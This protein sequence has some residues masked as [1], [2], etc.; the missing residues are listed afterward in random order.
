MRRRS[1]LGVLFLV[2]LL[3]L[4]SAS[5]TLAQS[6]V[7]PPVASPTSSTH[8]IQ[9]ADMDLSVDPAQD[10]Y[11]YAN[12]NWLA[13]AEIPADLEWLRPIEELFLRIEDQQ[14]AQLDRLIASNTL[15]EGSDQWK[16]VEFFKQG[17]DIDT[18]NAHGISPLQPQLD[19]I[20]S[21]T[22]L[23]QLHELMASP[24]FAGTPDFFN[25]EI[26][27]DPGDST[28]N[29]AWLA[30]P[31]LGLPEVTYYTEDSEDNIAARNAYKI[32]ATQLFQLTGMSESDAAAAAQAVYDFEAS[33][34]AHMVTSIEAQDFSV[35]YNPTSLDDMQKLYP[36]LDWQKYMT[37]AGATV[38]GSSI[39]IDSEVRLMQH[40]AD[41]LA[42]TDLQ[43]IENYL[44]LQLMLTAAPYLSQQVWDIYFSFLQALYGM[45]EQR[46]IERHALYAVNL[47]MPEALGQ[48]YVAEYFSPEAKADV[49]EL[50]ANLIASF[51]VR[52]EN[53]SW[54]SQETKTAAIEKLDAMRVKIGYPDK[55]K[56]YEN[57]TVGDSFWET[58]KLS[59]IAENQRQMGTYGQP[60][61]MGEWWMAPQTVNAGYTT[62][63]NDI[64]F[65]AG[66][67]Q[68][69][70]YDPAADPASN[71]GGI[72]SVIGHEI[73]HAF[74]LSGSQ[75]DKDG[76][77]VNWWTEADAAE[78]EAL[79]DQVIAQYNEVEVL[80]GL[81][82]NGE[83]TVTENVADMGGL[84]GAF[85][86]LQ[87]ALQKDGDP[88]EIDGFTQT[89]R[90]F[91]AAAQVWHE[92]ARDEVI[93][94]QNQSDPH[95]PGVVR[96]TRP[97]QQID[98]F[99]EAFGIQP[100]DAMYLPPEERIVIW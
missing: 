61:D 68:P 37:A 55:W 48:L 89:Q 87:L 5:I 10:F 77:F 15:E 32:T 19:V 36:A 100:G 2:S 51:R 57:Y 28:V 97:L 16:A 79:N 24:A 12:G 63:K 34:A 91:I 38:D 22:D 60:V 29:T 45:E 6:P 54:M 42:A 56:S 96:G 49:E 65:P 81:F 53:N 46:P 64:M 9:L 1:L 39:V 70:F 20:M 26:I 58:V 82:L 71:Y 73:T 74:D 69:P 43:V 76:N 13:H 95:S 93:R 75:F 25:V 17:I 84:Q 40:L 3:A 80:P 59:T 23:S 11:Q 72:G 78:F 18:R 85:D 4:S 21:A 7:A 44:S 8:G 88:G 90:F 67:L 98:A 30:G 14:L 52:L 35:I 27:A 92:K 33:M 94:T 31:Q 99:A 66:I 50:V 83:L 41:L 86:A 47:L 62:F